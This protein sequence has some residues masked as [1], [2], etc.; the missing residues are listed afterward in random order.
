MIHRGPVGFVSQS[1]ALVTGTYRLE[2]GWT[3]SVQGTLVERKV[4]L[5]RIDSKLG[6][7]MELEGALSGDRKQIRGSW[8][9]YELAGSE[10]GSGQWSARRRSD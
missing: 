1:G 3:G 7:S 10:G 6:R 4:Y 9:R 2:G 5:V 8:L